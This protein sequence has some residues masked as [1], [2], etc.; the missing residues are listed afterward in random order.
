MA[1]ATA[2]WTPGGDSAY[3]ALPWR[4]TRSR[5]RRGGCLLLGSDL[6]AGIRV[7]QVLARSEQACSSL[8]TSL[9]LPTPAAPTSTT[10]P[11]ACMPH[12]LTIV[13]PCS[14]SSEP[15]EIATAL[16]PALDGGGSRSLNHLLAA[17]PAAPRPA[18]RKNSR[19]CDQGEDS[20]IAERR[21]DVAKMSACLLAGS[22]D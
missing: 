17:L 16:L 9:L 3:L 6:G 11:H 2:E 20:A 1:W 22:L 14:A 7:S 13:Q 4:A 21:L 19:A 5:V 12:A 18:V 15:T 8:V 10:G